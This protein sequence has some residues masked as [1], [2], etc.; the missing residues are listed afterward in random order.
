MTRQLPK[1][2]QAD[3]QAAERELCSRSLAEFVRRSW[4]VIEPS[5]PLVWG[6]VMDVLCEHLE[7]VS[8]G[9]IKRLVANVPPG[10]MKSIL[11]GVMLPAFEWGPRAMPHHRYLG[12]AHSQ[13]LAMRD[14]RRCRILIESQWYQN[15][16]PVKITTDQNTKAKFENTATGFREAMAFSSLTGSRGSRVLCDDPHSVDSANSRIQLDATVQN[17]REA[18]PSRVNDKDSAIVIIMQRL[19][20]DDVS[21]VALELGY[22]HLCIPMR[23]EPG[24]SRVVVGSGDP[25]TETGELMFPERFDEA[26]VVQLENSLGPFGT[27]GQLQQRPTP[28]GG[29][30]FKPN[31]IQVV[32]AAPTGL[33]WLRGWDFAGTVKQTSDYTASVKMAIDN[34][35]VTWIADVQNFRESPDG[36]ERAVIQTAGLDKPGKQSFPRDPGQ[37]GVA[38]E[39]NLS[40]KLRGIAFSFSPESGDKRS[41]AMPFAAQVNVGNVR[42]VR[43]PNT[44]AYLHQLES[45]PNG[46]HDDMVDASSRAYNAISNS[47]NY[48]IRALA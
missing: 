5:T 10:S 34:D 4:H 23:Y 3:I 19:A 6:W 37:A 25:R 9:E 42:L 8:R 29:G 21:D 40:K 15:R 20:E 26:S 12:T 33:R 45:F 30:D 13:T 48:N 11:L 44:E 24:R 28:R 47:S 39:S 43:G 2:T 32:D 36:V 7:A 1:I 17:F 38:Q 22:D 14:S 16:W 41:R 27:A 18:L 35:G 46:A 31:M